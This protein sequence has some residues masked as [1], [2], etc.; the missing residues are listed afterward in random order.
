MK[1]NEG[2]V[3]HKNITF[4]LINSFLIKKDRRRKE[5]ERARYWIVALFFSLIFLLRQN[6]AMMNLLKNKIGAIFVHIRLQMYQRFVPEQVKKFLLTHPPNITVQC[7]FAL[8]VAEIIHF[9]REEIKF[10]IWCRQGREKGGMHELT[11]EEIQENK[12]TGKVPEVDEKRMPT[13]DLLEEPTEEIKRDVDKLIEFINQNRRKDSSMVRVGKSTIPKAGLGLFADRDITEGERIRGATYGGRIMNFNEAKKIPMKE[14]DYV[15]AL[16]LNVHVDAKEHYGY[17]A[18]YINDTYKTEKSRNCKFLKM[19]V[20]NRASVIAMRDIE[21]GEELFAEYGSGYWRARNGEI[22]A[23]R[24]D[25]ENFKRDMEKAQK[26][27]ES[28]GKYKSKSK[29]THS[30]EFNNAADLLEREG[31]GLEPD[32]IFKK[33]P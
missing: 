18:R 16:H 20:E 22:D 10:Q 12:R 29:K 15:M 11:E 5:K 24:G 26:W 27:V 17:M 6:N 4:I 32:S 1:Q 2:K 19:S 13:K 23:D 33:I 31:K 21:R 9:V 25:V 28:K 30:K 7:L 8:C 14:K 3:A